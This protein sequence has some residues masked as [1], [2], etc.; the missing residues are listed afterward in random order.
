MTVRFRASAGDDRPAVLDPDPRYDIVCRCRFCG[1]EWRL[2]YDDARAERSLRR[3]YN[4]RHPMKVQPRK[5]TTSDMRVTAAPV[6]EYLKP[7]R[8]TTKRSRQ[9]ALRVTDGRVHPV[10]IR[11]VDDVRQAD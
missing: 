8:G 7:S 10:T 5:L 6:V 2:E 9:N 3:H 11:R 4:R 1:Q